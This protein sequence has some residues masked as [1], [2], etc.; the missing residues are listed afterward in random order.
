[1]NASPI[2][3][4]EFMRG[5]KA[6]TRHEYDRG[7]MYK[8]AASIVKNSW[9][10][11]ADMADGLG[12]LLLTWNQAFYRYGTFSFEA[13]EHCI[14]RNLRPLRSCRRRDILTLS[15]ED[16]EMVGRLFRD[17]LVALQIHAGKSKG[18]KSP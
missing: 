4:A 18:R 13:L 7:A 17:L 12:V 2:T 15:V 9:G 5:C 14:R 16:E 8:V 11:P 6:Y 3:V 1:M 10:K